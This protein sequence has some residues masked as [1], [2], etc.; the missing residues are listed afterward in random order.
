M[1]RRL[2]SAAGADEGSTAA[3]YALILGLV[4]VVVVAAVVFLGASVTGLFDA[5][6]STIS[7]LP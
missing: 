1:R 6:A 4:A 7:D 5:T 2:G 3:E